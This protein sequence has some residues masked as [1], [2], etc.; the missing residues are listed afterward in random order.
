[1]RFF[2]ELGKYFTKCTEACSN[3]L[4]GKFII[5]A[6]VDNAGVLANLSKLKS[7]INYVDNE[8]T[9]LF[10]QLKVKWLPTSYC[11]EKT[12]PGHSEPQSKNHAIILQGP[13]TSVEG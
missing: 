6:V 1:M 13:G 12:K 10:H 4:D 9:K 8:I 2:V 7:N 5:K 3:K 11:F